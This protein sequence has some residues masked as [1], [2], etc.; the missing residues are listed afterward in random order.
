MP[1]VRICRN[2]M[3]EELEFVYLNKKNVENVEDNIAKLC[4][5]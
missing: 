5:N 2:E 4:G 1:S 3:K